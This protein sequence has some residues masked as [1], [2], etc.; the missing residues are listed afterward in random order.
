MKR[1]NGWHHRLVGRIGLLAA[2]ITACTTTAQAM[3]ALAVKA[4]QGEPVVWYESS[5]ENQISAVLKAFNARYPAVKVKH[6]RIVGGNELASRTIQEVQARGYTADLLT[7]G[8]DHLW[9]LN[10][11]GLLRDL[12]KDDL[13]LSARL[14]P[15][16]YA[17]PTAASVYVLL[18]NTRNVN[19]AQVPETWD[20]VIH[21]TWRDRIGSWVRAAAFAQLASVW[22][23]VKTRAQL[24]AF[25]QLKPYL[26]KST[27]PLA[28]GVASG[29]VDLA[30]GFYHSAQPVLNAGAPVRYRMLDPTPMHTISSGVSQSARNPSG[31]LLLLHWLT[32][33]EGARAYEEATSRGNPAV[34]STKT[35]AMLQG[36]QT[37]EWPFDKVLELAELSEQYNAILAKS[38]PAK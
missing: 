38:R 24:D 1:L 13:G 32:T 30:I 12:S 17:V 11:R 18:W 27:F 21:P 26:F 6:V 3:Q 23:E 28:Q 25:V 31:A 16:H 5:P 7:G 10:E 20:A 2:L 19:A 29:E 14:L 34:A 35:Y 36:V 15:V 9:R 4:A 37:A 8:Q 22:G 33:D